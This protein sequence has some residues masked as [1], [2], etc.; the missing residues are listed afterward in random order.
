MVA[1]EA[2]LA[3][4]LGRRERFEQRQQP[5]RIAVP[6][7]E[8]DQQIGIA[9]ANRSKIVS[10][11]A[12]VARFGFFEATFLTAFFLPVVTFTGTVLRFAFAAALAAS[13][14]NVDFGIDFGT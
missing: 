10:I 1:L 12:V 11:V 13:F 7:M 8:A 14:I 6:I 4:R 9:A 3:I 2:Q 5:R